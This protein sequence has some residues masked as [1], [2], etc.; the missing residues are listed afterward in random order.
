MFKEFETNLE[1]DLKQFNYLNSL[2]A[3]D[4]PVINTI[5]NGCA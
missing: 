5:K 3:F 4:Y 2:I 1:N